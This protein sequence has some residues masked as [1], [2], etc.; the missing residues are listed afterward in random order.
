MILR[1]NSAS[2]KTSCNNID[3]KLIQLLN[4]RKIECK[5]CVT[6]VM[7]DSASRGERCEVEPRQRALHCS[8]TTRLAGT[9]PCNQGH[10]HCIKISQSNSFSS[11]AFVGRNAL[12][13]SSFKGRDVGRLLYTHFTIDFVRFPE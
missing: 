10:G 6:S 1:G 11:A 12:N 3:R 9:T 7:Y 4:F 13:Y 5:M 8:R 2:V